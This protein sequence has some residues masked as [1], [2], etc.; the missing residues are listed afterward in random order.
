MRVAFA[1]ALLLLTMLAG[2]A[3]DKDDGAGSQDDPCTLEPVLCDPDSYLANHHC[4][5]NDIRPR[6]YAPD[7]PGPDS[8]ADPWQAGDAWTYRVRSGDRDYSSTLVYYEDIDYS[9]GQPQHYL[10][11]SSSR[12]EAFDHALFSINPMLGRIHRTLY[13]PHESGLHADMFNFP[14]CEGATWV[15]AFYDAT[16]DLTAHQTPLTL[17]DGTQDPLAFTMDGTSPDGSR[18]THTYS[19]AAK[20]FTKIDLQRA[21]GLRVQMDLTAIAHGKTGEQ[22]FLR[23][24]QDERLDVS[25]IDRSITVPRADGGEGPYDSIGV[26]MDVQRSAGTGRLEVHLRDSGGVSRACVGF[27]GGLLGT[28]TCPADPL[29]AEVGYAAGDWTVTVE[30]QPGDLQ[31]KAS[32]TVQLVSIYDRSG[33]V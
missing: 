19:P 13:S 9:N 3:D 11:G 2:C 4:I 30:V 14:L 20:W 25:L 24:Q 1:A 12:D 26:W 15:T 23:G 18:L 10:V 21:D 27:A 32:G 31:T 29:K 5:A 8:E 33:T 28:T 22:Y 7:T 16:F 17:P 6:I